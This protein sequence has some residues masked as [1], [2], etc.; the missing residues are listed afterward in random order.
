ML[1]RVLR[2]QRRPLLVL[3]IALAVN[4]ALYGLVVRPMSRRVAAA[5]ARAAS[6]EQSRRAAAAEFAA[7]RE[8][9]AGKA[10][11]EVELTTFYEK[12]LPGDLSA[13]QR[14]T[15]VSLARLARDAGLHLARR[16]AR[17]EHVRGA[18][19]D[20]LEISIVLEGDYQD[21]RQFIHRVETAPSFVVIDDLAIEQG[22]TAGNAGLRL[23]LKLS[24]YYRAE[25]HGDD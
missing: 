6:A 25:A 11:A 4:L 17:T 9:A 21:I 1:Q 2:E 13:A 16:V 5:D 12:V 24:T 3:A 8:L 22:A 23:S 15:Y 7:A 20:R 10:Q 14:A 19:L 18:S